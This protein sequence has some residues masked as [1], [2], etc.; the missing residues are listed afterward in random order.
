MP[1]HCECFAMRLYVQLPGGDDH[2]AARAWH[3]IH[4]AASTRTAARVD[5]HQRNLSEDS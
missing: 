4:A 3:P 2:R 1:L 5:N